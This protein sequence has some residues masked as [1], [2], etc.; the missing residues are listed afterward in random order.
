MRSWN[1]K[2]LTQAAYVLC[3][4][5]FVEFIGLLSISS[6]QAV[7]T[8]STLTTTTSIFGTVTTTT[9]ANQA[10]ID[11][12][13]AQVSNLQ[14]SVSNLQSTVNEDSTSIDALEIPIIVQQNLGPSDI[15]AGYFVTPVTSYLKNTT[16]IDFGFASGAI[17]TLI[18]AKLHRPEV[19]LVSATPIGV[20][21]YNCQVR[22]IIPISLSEIPGASAAILVA[23]DFTFYPYVVF[24]AQV[25]TTTQTV[26]NIQPTGTAGVE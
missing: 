10:E 18:E 12:L 25:D 14:S 20:H 23:G 6:P 2:E 11:S 26:T 13:N 8:T 16:R 5:V 1:N 9:T 15:V 4:V 22:L 21:I 24:S 7:T 19:D 17:K 3:F